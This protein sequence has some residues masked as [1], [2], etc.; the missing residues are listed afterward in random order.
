M[1]TDRQT[2]GDRLPLHLAVWIDQHPVVPGWPVNPDR[3]FLPLWLVTTWSDQAGAQ[4]RPSVI[5]VGESL[6]DI[7]GSWPGVAAAVPMDSEWVDE[8][9]RTMLV[10]KAAS[11]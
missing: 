4:H 6:A 10:V 5:A 3:G 7:L 11:T 2:N 9:A 8:D 1:V